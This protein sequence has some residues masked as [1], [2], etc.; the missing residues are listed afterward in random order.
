MKTLDSSFTP[1]EKGLRSSEE[2]FVQS[3][4]CIERCL[5]PWKQPLLPGTGLAVPDDL[6]SSRDSAKIMDSAGLSIKACFEW[7]HASIVFCPEHGIR[8]RTPA[9]GSCPSCEKGGERGKTHF[10]LCFSGICTLECFSCS[11]AKL[12]LNAASQTC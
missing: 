2:T 5:S 6:I 12:P 11:V 10:R 1:A 3:D 4:K 9:L 8:A 7:R